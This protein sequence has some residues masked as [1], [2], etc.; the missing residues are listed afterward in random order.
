MV[1]T[2]NITLDDD[3][4]TEAKTVKESLGLTWAEFIE[5]A[6]EELNDLE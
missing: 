6:T 5:V 4:A 1:T 3:V 2:L